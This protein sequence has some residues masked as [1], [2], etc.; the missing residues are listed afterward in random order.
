MFSLHQGRFSK[1]SGGCSVHKGYHD[2]CGGISIV[3]WEDIMIHVGGGILIK[4]FDLC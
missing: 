3:H 2:S 4:A 1:S